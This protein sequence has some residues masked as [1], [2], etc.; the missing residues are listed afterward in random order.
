[1]SK[2]AFPNPDH[3][4]PADAAPCAVCRCLPV[5]TLTAAEKQKLHEQSC[6]I[7]SLCDPACR[8][9]SRNRRTHPRPLSPRLHPAISTDWNLHE[10][11]H[12]IYS[13]CGSA[14][15]SQALLWLAGRWRRPCALR[16]ASYNWT[17]STDPRAGQAGVCPAH[18]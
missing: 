14:R 1:M 8:S 4:P 5:S 18:L 17:V 15:P 3:F 12:F 7:Y 9:R 11:S 6:F 10:Q 13:L 16:G 2:I